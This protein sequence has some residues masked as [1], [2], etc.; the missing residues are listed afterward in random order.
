MNKIYAGKYLDECLN[1]ASRELNVA[2]EELNYKIIK[3]NHS[4][5]NKKVEI[6]V[7]DV[8]LYSSSSNNHLNY[9]EYLTKDVAKKSFVI[10]EDN[11]IANDENGVKVENGN[12]VVIEGLSKVDKEQITIKPCE[13][14]KLF[15]NGELCS[16]KGPYEITQSDKIDYI[17][18]KIEQVKKISVK[19][20][21]DKM[22]GYIKVE[23]K[24]AYVYKLRD[25]PM[26]KDL[27]LK[28]MKV[29]EDY[30]KNIH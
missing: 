12:I 5:I 28:A 19:I 15:I 18:E 11:I 23:Y 22:K 29:E 20:S 21:V 6:E 4:F 9:T 17:G 25:K 10:N 30:P 26:A 8:D 14:I 27:I 24:P 13:K 2:E 7:M 16:E 1:N 3:D